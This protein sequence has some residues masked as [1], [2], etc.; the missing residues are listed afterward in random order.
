MKENIPKLIAF[1]MMLLAIAC[2]LAFGLPKPQGGFDDRLVVAILLTVLG[3]A[4]AIVYL[5]QVKR[6]II[7]VFG[8]SDKKS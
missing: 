6:E 5:E 8:N 3:L 4:G 1:I 7:N 2:P